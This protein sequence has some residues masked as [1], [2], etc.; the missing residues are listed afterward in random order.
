MPRSETEF[1]Q[2]LLLQHA[3]DGC[4]I[5]D[6]EGTLSKEMVEYCIVE[7]VERYEDIQHRVFCEG[8]TWKLPKVEAEELINLGV[9]VPR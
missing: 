3:Q 8:D 2:P 7:V 5:K 9:A 1:R 6:G 4:Y